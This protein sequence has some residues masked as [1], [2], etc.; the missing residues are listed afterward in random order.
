[1][2]TGTTAAEAAAPGGALKN[3]KREKEKEKERDRHRHSLRKEV[4]FASS[5]EKGVPTLVPDRDIEDCQT[6]GN[7]ID[8]HRFASPTRPR[9]RHEVAP[10]LVMKPG[11]LQRRRVRTARN[12]VIDWRVIGE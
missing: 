6:W 2:R 12:Q 3:S 11:A 8:G 10:A 5:R 7:Q 9:E 1:M 4:R